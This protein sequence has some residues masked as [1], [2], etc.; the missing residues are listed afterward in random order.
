VARD[1][2]RA[3]Q[4]K[5]RRAAQN[6]GPSPSEPH[7]DNV[8]GPLEHAS[9]EV[10]EFDAALVAGADGETVDD[11]ERTDEPE[12]TEDRERTDEPV[13]EAD[14]DMA[15]AQAPDREPQADPEPAVEDTGSVAA[16]APADFEDK[17]EYEYEDELELDG[18][19]ELDD[20]ERD[21]AAAGA[22]RTPATTRAD[23]PATRSGPGRFAAF[24]RAS[25]AELQR[26]QWPDRRQ[27]AQAT[28][29]VLGFVVVAGVYLGVADRIAQEVVDFII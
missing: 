15:E 4:R 8:P 19:E 6:P 10:D 5:A 9:G 23:V 11:R 16:P 21:P 13:V 26:V 14:Q 27:V 7:R 22:S 3:K 12:P 20:D 1:R 18:E 25:W 29:V 28:A 2:Q 17:D 24:V